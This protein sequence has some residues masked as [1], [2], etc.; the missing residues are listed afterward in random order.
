MNG[1]T[2]EIPQVAKTMEANPSVLVVRE[3]R[4]AYS[5]LLYWDGYAIGLPVKVSV[6]LPVRV[7]ERQP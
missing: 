5:S 1:I 3:E 2:K 7:S 6:G 4:M